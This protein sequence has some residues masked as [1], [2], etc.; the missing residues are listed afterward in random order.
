M[1]TECHVVV[2]GG[3]PSLAADAAQL[4]ERLEARW[5]RFRSGSELMRLNR[6]AGRPVVVS[7]ETFDAVARAVEGWYLT[8]GRFDPTVHT[9]LVANGYDRTFREIAAG[10]DRPPAAPPPAPAPGCG[11]IVLL[12]SSRA[13][14]LP[15]GVALDLGGIGKGLAADLVVR[16]LIDRGASGACVNLG[17]DVRVDGEPPTDA[18]WDVAVEDP[19]TAGGELARVRLASGAVVTTTRLFRRWTAGGQERHH[20]LDPGTGRPAWTG[21]AAVTVVAAEAASAE[22]VAKA[23]FMAGVEEGAAL[24]EAAGA[25]GLLVDDTGH[26][27]RLAALEELFA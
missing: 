4:V 1:G 9:A 27:T 6:H 3:R 13:V 12:P 21:L 5:S 24:I 20:L 11:S 25:T 16:A 2:V 26:V 18:G 22:I 17:G 14:I 15:P 10:A 23:A 8:A 19:F 7:R